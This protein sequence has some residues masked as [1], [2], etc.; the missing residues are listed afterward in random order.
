MARWAW[1]ANK[2]GARIH[3][4]AADSLTLCNM[5]RHEHNWAADDELVYANERPAG[6]RECL[7]CL[8]LLRLEH[9]TNDRGADV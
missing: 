5:E 1:I 2:P 3:R 4:V 6:Y 7:E 8:R 9:S